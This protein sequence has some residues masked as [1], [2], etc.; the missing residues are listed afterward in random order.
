M[1][2]ILGRTAASVVALQTAAV[3]RAVH[4]RNKKSDPT[5]SSGFAPFTPSA[6][7]SLFFFWSPTHRQRVYSLISLAL[8]PSRLASRETSHL[9]LLR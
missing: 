7:H 5:P 3:I 1:R 9:I 2:Q 4:G 8:T 6:S